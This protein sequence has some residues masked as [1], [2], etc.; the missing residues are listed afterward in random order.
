MN[1]NQE[2]RNLDFHIRPTSAN[3]Y[4]LELID[5]ASSTLLQNEFAYN[6]KDLEYHEM[7]SKLQSSDGELLKK[8]GRKL[9]DMIFSAEQIGYLKQATNQY[10]SLR[11]RFIID[12]YNMTRLPWELLHD[13]EKFL[14]LVYP[15]SRLVIETAHKKIENIPYPLRILA[16]ISS[17]LDLSENLAL[18]IEREQEIIMESLDPLVSEGKAEIVF[19]EVASVSNIQRIVTE[20]E[21]HI[22]HSSG[23]SGFDGI[24]Q[25]S[26]LLLEDD[27]GRVRLVSADEIS[28]LCSQS[29]STRLVVLR[30]CQT[31]KVSEADFLTGFPYSLLKRNV[32][33]YVGFQHSIPDQIAVHFFKSLYAE[34]AKNHPIDECVLQARVSIASQYDNHWF[35][36]VLF[37]KDFDGKLFHFD[38][39]LPPK[40]KIPSK[41]FVSQLPDV[42]NFVGRRREIREIRRMLLSKR[43][44]FVVIYGP[45]GI[46][47]TALAAKV[48][49]SVANEFDGILSLTCR[50]FASLRDILSEINKALVVN[51]IEDFS[52]IVGNAGMTFQAVDDL[53]QLLNRLKL[54]LIFD[55]FDALLD[56]DGKIK[57]E[58]NLFFRML[59]EKVSMSKILITS[60]QQI[61]FDDSLNQ[62]KVFYLALDALTLSESLRLMDNFESL[63]KSEL[64]TKEKIYKRLGGHPLALTLLAKEDTLHRLDSLKDGFDFTSNLSVFLEARFNRLSLKSQDIM[65]RCSVLGSTF[66]YQAI[67]SI[68]H[69][70]EETDLKEVIDEL[71]QH[72]LIFYDGDKHEYS[73]HPII[74]NFFY[75]KLDESQRRQYHLEAAKFFESAS[76]LT[77]DVSSHIEA[78]FH[79]FEA[80][81]YQK[82]AVIANNIFWNLYSQGSIE[83]AI[84]LLTE[85]FETTE[86][87]YRAVSSN[88]LG[89]LFQEQGRYD[90]AIRLYN[91]SLNIKR[92]LNDQKG[93]AITLH[94]LGTIHQRQGNYE[95]AMKLYTESREIAEG[96][97][98]QNMLAAN[99]YQLGMIAQSL[100]DYD[101]AV[102]YYH[103]S[104]KIYEELELK[105]EISLVYHQLANIHYQQGRYEEALRY[106]NNSLRIQQE[107]GNQAGIANSLNNIGIIYQEQSGYEEA[108]QYYNEAL[109]IYQELSNQA[110]IANSLNN[111]GIIYQEQSRY[112]EALRYYNNSLRIQQELGNQADVAASLHNIG[113]I[114]QRQGRYEEA[115]RY[116]NEALRID[117]ELGNQ[118][119]VAHSFG[120]ISNLYAERNDDRTAIQYALRALVIFRSLN[121]PYAQNV[122]NLLSEINQRIG[123]A[124]FEKII[125]T[126]MPKIEPTKIQII[127][128]YSPFGINK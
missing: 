11:L 46:G 6:P 67:K 7:L 124:E 72:G 95:A 69:E 109:H 5:S 60:R 103:Q 43:T 62:H 49:K 98:D 85:T 4:S 37:S 90:E 41:R 127:E 33:A 80:K 88:N 74:K 97:A 27:N 126:E 14:G 2:I 21:Y 48:S 111:I 83:L 121:L 45:A 94:Q 29:E 87:K 110:G 93:I 34:I 44:N 39:S 102:Q 114:R 81:E 25:E 105:N 15:I 64:S 66:S 128:Q 16:I 63:A 13:G 26:Y 23:H 125:Q 55:E 70:I 108:L 36:P 18:D 30:G 96:L 10:K 89:I 86:G 57:P 100:G 28:Y 19:V 50:P 51:G 106:Y 115:L 53:I 99:L 82:A 58:F 9:Y 31:A 113:M 84:Q 32:S 76:G 22:I 91:E 54:I 40:I 35:N 68:C 59:L 123:D 38:K 107:L 42:R 61:A 12:D 56:E 17:P 1:D 79:Y 20:E 119:G 52:R 117:Q 24:S 104:M 101:Q 92:Q 120:Q 8:F 71:T 75:E 118:V 73:I 78:R 116:Y 112:E 47:K 65:L 3:F 77:S 122:A